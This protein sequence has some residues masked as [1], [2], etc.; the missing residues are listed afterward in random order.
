LSVR[1]FNRFN[2]QR[3]DITRAAAINVGERHLLPYYDTACKALAKAV[4]IDEVKDIRDKSRA[5]QVYAEQAKN[6]SLEQNAIMLRLRAE[7]RIGE[8]LRE[9]KERSERDAGT[10]G[11]RRSRSRGAT[12]KLSDLGVTKSQSSR[13]QRLADIDPTVFEHVVAEACDK[14]VRG[15][16]NAVREIE[17]LQEREAYRARTK[18]GGTV[19]DLE[20][21]VASGYRAATI[22][23]DVPSKFEVYSGKG[24]QRAAE[25]YYDTMSPDE[26]KA[27]GHLVRALA[28]K[29]CA[30]FYWTSGPLDEQAHEIIRAWGFAYKT[31]GFV[32]VKTKPASGTPDLVDLT[33]TDLHR[34]MG[35]HT[36]ANVEVVLL[37]T[38]GSPLRLAKNVHQVVIAPVGEHS[39]KP[40]EVYRRIER[41]YP[42]PYLELFA[43]KPRERW[44]TWGNELRPIV[45]RTASTVIGSNRAR[46]RMKMAERER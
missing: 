35:Y 14:A 45:A 22:L 12:V 37:A 34:G 42:G 43:R 30:L 9:M 18:E 8:L 29:D 41:L 2:G 39:E 44:T 31:W 20:A 36:R 24:K 7:R 4:R 33:P 1:R 25:R 26:L 23:V 11:D 15:V 10:G 19:T 3:R 6:H 40:D 16:R 27:M 38:R 46:S 28:A 13:W 17:I 32:W 21:L 5:M